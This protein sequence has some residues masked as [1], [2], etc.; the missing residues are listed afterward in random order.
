MAT[1]PHVWGSGIAVAAALQAVAIIPPF[2][3]TANPT[4]LL[5]E[6]VIEFDR[7]Y[8]PLRDDLL[9]E[10]FTLD[11]G[12]LLIPAQAGLGVSVRE[13]VLSKYST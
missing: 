10:R 13:D 11:D 4:A 9:H 5:N 3:H 8:N 12:C 1:I 7:K 6:P 2:P